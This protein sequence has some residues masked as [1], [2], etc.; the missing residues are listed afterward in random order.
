[1]CAS[2]GL[3]KSARRNLSMDEPAEENM[4]DK[5]D[6]LAQTAYSST[7]SGYNSKFCLERD[8]L[9]CTGRMSPTGAFC[10]DW[11]YTSIAVVMSLGEKKVSLSPA[12]SNTRK[13]S[14]IDMGV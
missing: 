8:G 7:R 9:A 3:R 1:M 6:N 14:V 10:A 13:G 12:A 2:G 11:L 4:T 5:Q